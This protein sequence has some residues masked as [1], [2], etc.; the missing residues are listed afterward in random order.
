MQKAIA[1]ENLINFRLLDSCVAVGNSFY[2]FF[3]YYPPNTDIMTQSEKDA[4]I[5]NLAALLDTL[6]RSLTFFATDKV[7]DLSKIKNFYASLHPRF[8]PYVSE[9]IASIDDTDTTSAAVQRAFYFIV[10]T[11]S[12]KTDVYNTIVGKGYRID[13][14]G[15]A[16]LAVLL[17][18]YFVR[19]FIS[20]DI[21]TF[22]ENLLQNQKFAKALKKR[23]DILHSE[24]E[25]H[26]APHRMDFMVHYGLSNN[27]RRKVLMVKN[28]P[29]EIPRC[30]LLKVATMRG[31]TFTMRLTPMAGSEV[32]KMTNNQMK[33]KSWQGGSREATAQIESSS[34][35]MSLIQ[36]YKD[37]V[38]SQMTVY[39]TSI[40]IECYG[41][42]ENELNTIVQQVTDALADINTSCETLVREQKE[43]FLSVNPLGKD[44]FLSDA[45]N[46]PSHTIAAMYPFSYSSRL[47]DH[48]ILFG[49]TFG[50]G[51]LFIDLLARFSTQTNS[52][53]NIIG[54]T[55]MGKSYLLK[56]IITFLTMFG[57]TCFTLDPEDEYG[58]LFRNLGGTVYNCVSGSARIN[59]LEVRCLRRDDEDDDDVDLPE[60]Q[61]M[62]M[63]LQHL[64]WLKDF[65]KVLFVG[66]DDIDISALMM[67]T[68]EM[69]EAHHITASSHFDTLTPGDYPILSDLYQ[70]IEGYDDTSSRIISRDMVGR[71]LLR[72]RECYDGPLSIIFNGATNI[73]NANMICFSVAQLLEGSKDRTQAVLFNLTTWIWSQVTKRERRIAF[74]IDELYLFLENPIMVKYI[75]SFVKRA[76]KYLAMIGVAT[77]QVAD[78]LRSDIEAYTTALFN[79]STYKFI[80][81]PGEIDMDLLRDKLKLT[82]G[83]MLR[84][85]SPTQRHCLIKA[86]SDKYYAEI[87]SFAFE[88]ELFG[89]AGGE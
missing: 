6:S 37:I 57:V 85:S 52:N 73:K 44:L 66:M 28:L 1:M 36:F 74:N 15:K 88:K 10:V 55:G 13:R 35:R 17:R 76:R 30:A 31:T 46:L 47:D 86:G 27:T 84:I 61:N 19:E 69:Y 56:K 67:L 48:G 65:F 49:T 23:P 24:I 8:D 60:L 26:L 62:S 41:K 89:A 58:T 68:Q 39:Y 78:C 79:N 12:D 16:E 7:E 80:F 4:E 83:E 21:Y 63:F 38:Q 22:E 43:G 33:Q 51:Q 14:S 34:E 45:N 29:N 50:G 2:H 87:G 32:R 54:G 81:Y 40:F 5:D 77:Q 20:N 9:I 70:Y 53:F 18:N 64:S 71:L 72:L 82:E 59:P 75:S 25:R 11:D 42:D 3:R